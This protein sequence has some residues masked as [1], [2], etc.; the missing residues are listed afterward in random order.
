[1][2]LGVV[3]VAIIIALVAMSGRRREDEVL[4][5]TRVE[6][7]RVGEP[8]VGTYE[9]EIERERRRRAS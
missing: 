6:T 1:V 3:V 4:T 2:I 9:S 8:P 7:R 5:D